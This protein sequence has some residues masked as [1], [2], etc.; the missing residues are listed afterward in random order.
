VILHYGKRSLFW[1]LI[2]FRYLSFTMV[3]GQKNWFQQLWKYTFF[4]HHKLPYYTLHVCVKRIFSCNEKTFFLCICS[5]CFFH[6]STF[7][8]SGYVIKDLLTRSALTELRLLQA[9]IG[10]GF[11]FC[12]VRCYQAYCT[13]VMRNC[14]VTSGVFISFQISRTTGVSNNL[15]YSHCQI[16]KWTQ[17]LKVH[18]RVRKTILCVTLTGAHDRDMYDV[19]DHHN[20]TNK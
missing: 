11:V 19:H 10:L 14:Y 4:K 20:D 9:T 6:N 5:F 13:L 17:K 18:V 1:S 12:L 8:H 3:R 7:F 15:A 16:T 2:I